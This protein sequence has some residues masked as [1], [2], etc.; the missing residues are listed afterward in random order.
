[1]FFKEFICETDAKSVLNTLVQFF[2]NF[3]FYFRIENEAT[4]FWNFVK[5]NFNKNL[6]LFMNFDFGKNIKI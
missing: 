6:R 4:E 2:R 1:M 5:M 3:K